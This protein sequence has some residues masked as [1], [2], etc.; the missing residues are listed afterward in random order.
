MRSILKNKKGAT[1][2]DAYPAVLTIVLIG[3]VL[4]IGLYVLSQVEPNVGG[5]TASTSINNTITG[6]GNL[7]TWMTVIVVVLAASIVLGLVL[8]SFGRGR[9]I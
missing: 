5:G 2:A 7:A 8:S 3:I 4:G 9:G 1:L 6:L